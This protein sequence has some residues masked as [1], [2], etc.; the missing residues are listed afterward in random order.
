[1][2]GEQAG[3]RSTQSEVEG[4]LNRIR[5]VVAVMSGKGGVDKSS[6]SALLA[7][8]LARRGDG[9]LD[10]DVTGPS[11][12][13]IFGLKAGYGAVKQFWNEVTC[14]IWSSICPPEPA[15]SP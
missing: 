2:N 14:I 7:S 5:H 15:T 13:K 10:A 1:M 3:A 11:I 6:I 12:P 4:G 9:I 8:S